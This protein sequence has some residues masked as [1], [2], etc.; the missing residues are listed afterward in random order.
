M[1][2]CCRSGSCGCSFGKVAVLMGGSS[3]REISLQSGNNVLAALRNKG[4][5]AFAIDV[6]ADIVEQLQATKP[7]RVFI[8]LHGE[9]EGGAIQ[10][11]LD[12]LNIPYPGS[13]VEASAITLNKI[14]SNL[15]WQSIGLLTIPFIV[16][17]TDSD[18]SEIVSNLGLPLCV[19]PA[20]GGSSCG[21]TKVKMLSE[22]AKAYKLGKQHSDLVMAQPW[23]DGRELT[24]SV[25]GN[26]ALPV[27]EIQVGLEF[28]DYEAKYHA[29]S[30]K[31]ICPSELSEAQTREVQNIALQAFQASG[32]KDWGRVDFILDKSDKFWLLEINTIPGLTSG[33]SGFPMAAAEI[34]IGFDDL[35]WKILEFSL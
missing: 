5:D 9:G 3:E 6:G 21:I 31:Y 24:V 29:D 19:K 22:F 27:V 23:I 7:E 20:C 30:T 33:H 2:C 15:L 26:R 32:C 34:G 8:A 4:V 13:G 16:L 28:Y 35:I 11:L 1:K 10:G 18:Y 14:Y 12:V 25:L 17:R